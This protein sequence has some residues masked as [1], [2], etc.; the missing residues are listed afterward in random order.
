MYHNTCYY[1]IT[2][3]VVYFSNS[4]KI[5]F[6]NF[7]PIFKTCVG[8]ISTMKFPA[9]S[10]YNTLCYYLSNAIPQMIVCKST[11]QLSVC[12]IP[13]RSRRAK[14]L[15]YNMHELFRTLFLFR[16]STHLKAAQRVF[17]N[18]T[19][20]QKSLWSVIHF[21]LSKIDK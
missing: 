16:K 20:V 11:E 12:S 8:S 3:L 13:I 2:L 14:L 19:T 7:F 10:W 9:Y 17:F 4:G 15:E 18:S 6:C 21:F 1:F 5:Y